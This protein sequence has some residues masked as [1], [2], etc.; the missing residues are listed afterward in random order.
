[1]KHKKALKLFCVNVKILEFT[2]FLNIIYCENS[3][4]ISSKLSYYY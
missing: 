2:T 1:M 4:N 3:R